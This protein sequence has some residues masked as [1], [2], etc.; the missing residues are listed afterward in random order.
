M[1]YRYLK[2]EGLALAPENFQ[3][4]NI[5]T[6]SATIARTDATYDGVFTGVRLGW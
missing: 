5:L 3:S 6:G 2:L 1:G 4:A